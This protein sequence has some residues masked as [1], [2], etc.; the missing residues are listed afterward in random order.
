M[1]RIPSDDKRWRTRS[2]FSLVNRAP[3]RRMGDRV[4]LRGS[5]R[6]R[7]RN[8]TD[9]FFVGCPTAVVGKF[10]D[11]LRSKSGNSGFLYIPCHG[12]ITPEELLEPYTISLPAHGHERGIQ[13]PQKSNRKKFN[14]QLCNISLF[15]PKELILDSYK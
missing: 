10:I 13:L 6:K 2:R 15:L 9:A 12:H 14:P 5:S 1:R 8:F 3:Y 11:L 7:N 4:F